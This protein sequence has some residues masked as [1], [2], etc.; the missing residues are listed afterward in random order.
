MELGTSWNMRISPKDRPGLEW[1]AS[2][3]GLEGQCS[4]R[5][6]W[7]NVVL[8]CS[9]G[10]NI[11]GKCL[12]M[13]GSIQQVPHFDL[14]YNYVDINPCLRWTWLKGAYSCWVRLGQPNLTVRRSLR[15]S[16][17]WF[18]NIAGHGGANWSVDPMHSQ[19]L[20]T[21]TRL[22]KILSSHFCS[23]NMVFSSENPGWHTFGS[24]QGEKRSTFS[25]RFLEYDKIPPLLKKLA[26]TKLGFL[27]RGI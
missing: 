15:L 10:R 22:A 23:D 6:K 3:T 12:E 5:R 26:L 18:S 21:P 7:Q 13:Y 8:G 16:C 27:P 19:V 4:M 11:W 17:P 20:A 24:A 2:E 25:P 1:E 9:L 14:K